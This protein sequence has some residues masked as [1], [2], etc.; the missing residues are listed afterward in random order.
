ML[1]LCDKDSMVSTRA[2]FDTFTYMR[3]YIMYACMYV[4]T[5]HTCTFHMSTTSN[6]GEK[7]VGL[8]LLVLNYSGTHLT[9]TH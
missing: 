6:L 3:M 5:Q 9:E 1:T 2:V 7:P 8:P 4:H